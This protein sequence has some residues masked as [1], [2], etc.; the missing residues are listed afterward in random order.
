MTLVFGE[1]ELDDA[2]FELRMGARRVEVQPKVLRLLLH[3]VA[4]RARAVATEELLSVLW[5]NE[6]VTA[7]SV[8]R[9]VRGARRALGDSG[10]SQES[11]RTVRGLGY[12]FV[13]SAHHR[14]DTR[15]G[16][17]PS[18]S[19][20]APRAPSPDGAFVGREGV[21]SVLA[22]SLRDALAGRGRAVLLVGEPGIGKTRTLHELAQRAAASDADIWLG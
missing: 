5:P 13:L 7:A 12:Q 14:D 6:T 19:M 15:M 10:D 22:S 8:K 16:D 2:R 11:I 1:Y 4:N 20:V 9:A 18:A 17:A 21:M 3:L